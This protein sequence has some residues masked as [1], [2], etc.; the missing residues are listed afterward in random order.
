MHTSYSLRIQAA[1]LAVASVLF[2]TTAASLS[3]VPPPPPMWQPPRITVTDQQAQP[4][5]LRE[6][7]MQ[8]EVLAGQATTRVEIKLFNPNNR[9]LEGELQF[10]L[11]AGQLV[12][13]FALDVNGSLRQ[14]V[15]VPKAKGQ[16]I[17]ED[18]RR[19]RVDPGL[20]E[21]TGGNQYK[22]RVYPI[23]PNNHRTVVLNITQALQPQAD[24]MAVLQMP[25][26]FSSPVE[27][28][29]VDVRVIGASAQATRVFRAPD[30]LVKA[31]EGEVTTLSLSRRNWLAEQG[32]S[33]WLQLAVPA[34]VQKTVL[35]QTGQWAG[36]AY[37]LSH[38]PFK[39]EPVARAQPQH[40]A[41][42]WD[43]SGAMRARNLAK[44][45][46]LLDAYFAS[47]RQPTTVSLLVVRNSREAV[48]SFT[49][50]G[51][52]GWSALQDALR[53]EPNDGSSNFDELPIPTQV[54]LTLLVSDG[55]PTDGKRALAYAHRAPLMA[56]SAQ[57]AT[58]APRLRA[59]A[60][61]TAGA[62]VD[63]LATDTAAA[64]A[65]LRTHGWRIAQLRSLGADQLIAPAATVVDGRFSVA[66]ALPD[67]QADIELQLAHPSGRQQTIRIPVKANASLSQQ[68]PSAV[69]AQQWAAWRSAQLAEDPV[70][71]QVALERLAGEFA[72]VGPNSSLIVLELASDYAR[73]GLPAPPELA[74]EVA[75][76]QGLKLAQ[77]QTSR[78]QQIEQ[79]VAQFQARQTW[80]GK[81]FP[82]V[83]P[84][85]KPEQQDKR[86]QS[87]GAAVGQSTERDALMKDGTPPRP[88]VPVA[89]APVAAPAPA[90]APMAPAAP[91][92]A[93]PTA[94][95]LAAAPAQTKVQDASPVPAPSQVTLQAW[96]P[97][98]PYA[99][100]LRRADT[101]QLYQVYLDERLA[102]AQ[103]SSFYMDAA[104]VF[105]DRKQEALGLRVLSN[106]AGMNLENRQLLRLY[107][108]RLMQSG[109]AARA[110]AVFDRVRVLAPNE[111]QSWRDL[112]LAQAEVGQSQDAVNNLWEVV[113]R[114]WNS[115][116]PGI[117]L[118]A[119]T[120]LNAIAA[121]SPAR[122]FGPVSLDSVD[123]RLRRNLP[124]ELRVT[125]AWDTD[126]TDVDLYVT[127]PL[128]EQAFYGRRLTLQGGNMSPDATGGYGPEEFSLK[129]P[130]PGLYQLSARFHSHRQ[131]VL[132][133]GTTLML[134]ISTGFGTPAWKDSYTTVRVAGSGQ[135]VRVGE[136][137]V[138]E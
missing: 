61:R 116:F 2:C 49:V 54:D 82:K 110:I 128:G 111:P 25:L 32:R 99:Q 26:M 122:G 105:F 129:S 117:N 29:K 21:A 33:D 135:T 88:S 66:G 109:Q 98:A 95:S 40:I 138:G 74:A 81:E 113:S 42:V 137:K 28:L 37:F 20:L 63:L 92:A 9:V 78:S 114:P 93:P 115:R 5:V 108:Y 90:P 70:L 75:R 133:E 55:L 104:S 15:P 19:R 23:L 24:G 131:Q 48:R 80:W 41:L 57:L 62:Y 119:L 52:Q 30:G 77:E 3:P 76:L 36:K 11:L 27:T 97:D 126:D 130:A 112:A 84:A 45:L 120:E 87:E 38:V 72:L 91:A 53:A 121:V 86:I 31:G 102:N 58:D 13:G 124:L 22:L 123:T 132:S 16:E 10:P 43:A 46:G 103:S 4:I 64:L 51:G 50:G 106:L 134:R 12:T 1:L 68:A 14:A 67:K 107:A 136:V 101:A 34:T 60:D 65:R 83:K 69:P 118:I 71:N 127:D 96:T 100:R 73:Y 44:T 17:F 59:L 39:D 56:I 94:S 35:T 85:A 79:V 47:L 8:T 6:V 89:R 125:M 18:I 7:L